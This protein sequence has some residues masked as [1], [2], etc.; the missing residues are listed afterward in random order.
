M[1]LDT[2]Q[3]EEIRRLLEAR[4]KALAEQLGIKIKETK[5]SG[6]KKK[7]TKKKAAKKKRAKRDPLQEAVYQEYQEIEKALARLEEQQERFGYCEHCF[8]E[9][10]WGELVANPARRFCS[11]CS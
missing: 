9:I 8:M 6:K 10:P 7:K 5:S 1:P 2:E 3:I 11:R 4:R